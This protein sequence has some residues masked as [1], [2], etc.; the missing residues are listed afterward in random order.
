MPTYE[1]ACDA[2]GHRFEQFQ[3]I[4]AAALRKCPACGKSRL[5]RL[6][7][8]GAAVLFNGGGF[9]ETDYRSDA[10]RKAEEAEK[11]AADAKPAEKAAGGDA[12]TPAKPEAAPKKAAASDAAAPAAGDAKGKASTPA[13]KAGK[14]HAREGRGVGN[15]RRGAG[16]PAGSSAK[17]T[18]RRNAGGR[19][20]GRRG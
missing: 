17:S 14:S 4:T 8:I 1:Y 19:R 12:A 2:C 16:P 10:Y 5:Q 6:I 15:L 18:P 11:S 9:Y 7:G 13:A 3:S 20:S